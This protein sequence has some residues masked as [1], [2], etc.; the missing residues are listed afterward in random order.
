MQLDDA[1]S[2][3]KL[4]QQAAKYQKMSKSR[5]KFENFFWLELQQLQ[6]D[7]AD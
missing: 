3:S 1:A 2:C 4:Q 5:K 6:L 7:A